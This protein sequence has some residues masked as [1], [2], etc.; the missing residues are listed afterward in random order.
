MP[1]DNMVRMA[2]PPSPTRKPDETMAALLPLLARRPR[3]E[4]EF[5]P[6]ALEI[7]E[8]PAPPAPRAIA[9]AICGFCC[10]AI[11]W[12]ILGRID[13]VANAPGT[14]VPSGKV[15]LVQ[16]VGTANLQQILV[17]DGDHVLKGQPVLKLDAVSALAA[18]DK[19]AADLAASRLAVAGL[20]ALRDQIASPG[21]A[22]HFSP[23]IGVT[24]AQIEQELASVSARSSGQEAKLASLTQQMAEKRVEAVEDAGAVD[25]LK[26][27]L[28]LLAGVRDMYA[29]LYAQRLGTTVDLL[30]SAQRFSD[31][32]HDLAIQIAHRGEAT[33]ELASLT[34]QYAAQQAD[35][36]HSVLQDLSEA[37]RTLG[38]DEASYRAAAHEA[39][40][41]VLRAPVTGTVQQLAVHS[42]HGVVTPGEK[43]MVIVPD[44]QHLVVEAM[45]PNR[46]I[47]F[48]KVGQRVQVK[49]AA[50]K[51]TQYGL[52]PGSVVLVSRDAVDDTTKDTQDVL[53]GRAGTSAE[54][55]QSGS[56]P[57]LDGG[58]GSGYVARIA[59]DRATLPVE[60]QTAR[61]QPG[62]AV[63]AEILTGRRRIISYLLSP[64]N[65]S[66]Q[67]AGR[68]R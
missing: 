17:A 29:K 12:S 33:T 10:V 34:K 65:R 61:L 42:S 35:Y 52:V 26:A 45:I 63:T 21:H 55:T 66:V 57:D 6:A 54:G 36:V 41:T 5:L 47:G 62:M 19:Q 9:M 11:V 24:L 8:T 67:D 43:L 64:L 58:E 49:V 31:A 40:E 37:Q 51:F 38:E 14:I 44:D 7:V 53:S 48:V 46:D 3:H 60:G 20:I 18:R 30:S 25:K 23:P 39:S 32:A 2:P 15:K 56:E 1:P 28:P 22:L 68:E 16:A 59:L 4:L 50:F 13:I 27:E